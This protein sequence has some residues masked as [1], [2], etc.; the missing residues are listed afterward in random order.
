MSSTKSSSASGDII[1][2]KISSPNN[3]YIK[4]EISSDD[5]IF[6][7]ISKILSAF[8]D[9][10]CFLE[11]FSSLDVSRLVFILSSYLFS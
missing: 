3:W 9:L 2:S 4:D 11:I 7:I 6:T 8:K 10:L 1:F 5:L